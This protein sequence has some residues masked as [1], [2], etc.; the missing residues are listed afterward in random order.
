[1][2]TDIFHVQALIKRFSSKED[3][4]SKRIDE[5]SFYEKLITESTQRSVHQTVL[6]TDT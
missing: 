5:K 3:F 4:N 6:L 1:M 2:Q